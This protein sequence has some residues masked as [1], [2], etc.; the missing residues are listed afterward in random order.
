MRTHEMKRL[1][2]AAYR[3]GYTGL[4]LDYYTLY[5]SL[6]EKKDQ[7]QPFSEDVASFNQLFRSFV[8]GGEPVEELL[9]LRDRVIGRMEILTAYVDCFQ[10][11]E[12]VL[13]RVERR[14]EKRPS[15]NESAEE[16]ADRLLGFLGTSQDSTIFNSRIQEVTRQLPIRYTKQKFYSLLSERMTLY[17]GADKKSLDDVFYMLRTSSMVLLPEGM[18]RDYGKLFEILGTLRGGDY[19]NLTKEQY[20][21]LSGALALGS[22]ILNQESGDYLLLE[23][24]INYLYMILLSRKDAMVDVAENQVFD[25]V[26]EGILSQFEDG[27]NRVLDD[28]V[29]ELLEQLEGIQESASQRLDIPEDAEDED[30]RRLAVLLSGSSFVRFEDMALKREADEEEDPADA[31][32]IEKQTAKFCEEL[33]QSFEAA[34]KAVMRAV[35]ANILSYLPVVFSSTEELKQY[36]AGSLESC[37]DAAEREACMELLEQELMEEDAFL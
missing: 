29:T 1:K 35:M 8:D 5:E 17:V 11:Y 24:I 15:K 9:A 31:D 19:K 21:N 4:A 28:A 26:T 3:Y 34:P 14:F 7:S 23:D 27:E 16:F 36:I 6:W 12:Y 30:I 22:E 13:N 33:N 10:I 2:T 32:W 18:E 25:R 20:D 37:S